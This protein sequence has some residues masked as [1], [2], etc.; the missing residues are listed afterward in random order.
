MYLF[1]VLSANSA[2]SKSDDHGEGALQ[3]SVWGSSFTPPIFEDHG[4]AYRCVLCIIYMV[5]VQV[6]LYLFKYVFKMSQESYFCIF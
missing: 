4:K 6:N 3:Y 5:T 2:V 1:T